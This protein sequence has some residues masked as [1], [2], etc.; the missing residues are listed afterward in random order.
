MSS[1]DLLVEEDE[2]QASIL[3]ADL[4]MINSERQ[5]MSNALFK[6]AVDVVEST[7]NE[8]VIVAY[9]EGWHLGLI[10]L[11]AG[12]LL[13]QYQKPVFVATKHGDKITGSGRS[14]PGF[15][16]TK[17]LHAASEYMHRFGGHPQACGFTV[18]GEE[19]FSKAMDI[20]RK[21][22]KEEI[23]PEKLTLTLDADCELSLD[24]IDIKLVEQI[25][26][27]EPF[28]KGNPK[29]I[30]ISRKVQIQVMKPVGK[31]AAHLRLQVSD[32][33]GDRAWNMI[34]FRYGYLLEEL[35]IGDTI[36]VAYELG[37]NDWN[38]RREIQ[39]RLVDIKY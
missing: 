31:E 37:F 14:I 27:M 29:P 16:L 34:G 2:I 38:G 24:D 33:G 28:G 18:L 19:N 20:A 23:D 22:A 7:D 11:V 5:K 17:P 36:D 21:M 6:E 3:A 32:K 8:H 15:D 10:G 26:S 13:S 30:F 12:K 9:G 35:S 39:L 4:D 1:F 25:L